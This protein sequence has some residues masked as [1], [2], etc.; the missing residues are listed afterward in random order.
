MLRNRGV[1]VTERKIREDVLRAYE[2][3]IF[4]VPRWKYM[5]ELGCQA[6]RYRQPRYCTIPRPV[7]YQTVRSSTNYGRAS[8]RYGARRVY[9]PENEWGASSAD[10]SMMFVRNPRYNMESYYPNE[11]FDR[12]YRRERY[13]DGYYT[14]RASS[15]YMEHEEM[16]RFQ[17]P[18]YKTAS[19]CPKRQTQ[20]SRKVTRKLSPIFTCDCTTTTNIKQPT[21]TDV[22][23]DNPKTHYLSKEA[24]NL[25]LDI[26][27][28]LSL[29]QKDR[30]HEDFSSRSLL[31]NIYDL[32]CHNTNSA[33]LRDICTQRVQ[34]PSKLPNQKENPSEKFKA[35]TGVRSK[36]EALLSA[37]KQYEEEKM[38]N[39]L[40]SSDITNAPNYKNVIPSDPPSLEAQSFSGVKDEKSSTNI[41]GQQKDMVLQ[42]ENPKMSNKNVCSKIKTKKDNM[43][44]KTAEIQSPI[45]LLK[46]TCLKKQP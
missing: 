24:N 19:Y 8:Q 30:E 26:C 11:V 22:D 45:I 23:N 18:R 31:Q 36:L 5:Q 10:E 35:A 43:Q 41:K 38:L 9:L 4:D 40:G 12:P 2:Y 21:N 27:K 3:D 39:E 46:I 28:I 16:E 32:E 7:Y 14:R 25:S 15:I 44:Q 42:T 1:N 17:A 34:I 37:L 6:N 29:L 33:A 20:L 13:P